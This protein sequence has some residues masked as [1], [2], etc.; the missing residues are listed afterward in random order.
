MYCITN[1]CIQGIV[2]LVS[3][4]YVFHVFEVHLVKPKTSIIVRN[5][6]FSFDLFVTFKCIGYLISVYSCL[7]IYF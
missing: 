3:K 6:V 4:H 1:L 2:G 5:I 7:L